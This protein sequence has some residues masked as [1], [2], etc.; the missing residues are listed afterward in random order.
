MSG[1]VRQFLFA[2][3]WG[4]MAGFLRLAQDVTAVPVQGPWLP[5][6][7]FKQA[8]VEVAGIYSTV[9]AGIAVANTLAPPLNGY[10]VT[11][12]GTVTAGDVVGITVAS[13][14]AGTVK[15]SHT[16]ASGDTVGTIAAALGVA[17]GADAALAAAGFMVSASA[18]SVTIQYPSVEP[19]ATW[20]SA[21]V[22]CDFPSTA[23]P[24]NYVSVTAGASAAATETAT[25]SVVNNGSVV[26]QLN[27]AT[28]HAVLAGVPARWVQA[29]V[30]A[31]TG[32]GAS[33]NVNLAGTA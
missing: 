32:A 22:V 9:L 21:G 7:L 16:V 33:V 11:V 20:E 10:K 18:A 12:G 14:V 27:A 28:S 31:L 26:Q 23:P 4:P 24:V 15:A 6:A 3:Q 13:S 30:T 5:C 8:S 29:D 2:P 19:G 1:T 25:V 17:L